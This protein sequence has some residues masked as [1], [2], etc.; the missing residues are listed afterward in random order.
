MRILGQ[1]G[2][3]GKDGLVVTNEDLVYMKDAEASIIEEGFLQS[4]GTFSK[5]DWPKED[6]AILPRRILGYALRERKFARFDV[7]CF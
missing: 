4:D 5:K 2:V 7:N 6:F 1:H 3:H